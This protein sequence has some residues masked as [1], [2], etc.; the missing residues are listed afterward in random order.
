MKKNFRELA[1]ESEIILLARESKFLPNIFVV[2]VLFL[3]IMFVG[4]AVSVFPSMAVRNLSMMRGLNGEAIDFAIRRL[5]L[6][7]GFSILAFFGWV[8]FIERR[9]IYT[10]G[11]KKENFFKKYIRGFV[12]GFSMLSLCVGI[13]SVFRGVTI[14]YSNSSIKGFSALSGILIVL[15]GWIVQGASEEIMVRG[16]LMPVIGVRYNAFLG[17]FV[18]SIIFGALHLGNDNIGVLPVINLVLFGVFAALYVIWE[19]GLWGICAVHT[20]W[21]WTQGNIF[22]F[23]VSGIIPAGGILIDLDPIKG[24]D[25]ITGGTFGVEGGLACSAVL[26]I[27]IIILIT[28]INKSKK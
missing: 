10:M 13:F 26:L 12:I 24:K 27:G 9:P 15:I 5:L 1:N 18:S 16:W 25:L 23:E 11:F 19:G 22:G 20:A 21:N 6:P 3:G 28:L 17:I 2:I 4:E 14:D 8:R 7:C